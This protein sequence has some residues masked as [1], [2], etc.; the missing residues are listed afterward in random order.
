M[1]G[2]NFNIGIFT[3]LSRDHLDYHKSYKDYLSSKLLLFNNLLKKNSNVITDIDIP[4]YKNIKNII[5]K[6]QL[7]ISTIGL[8]NSTLEL[9]KHRYKENKQLFQIKYKN[10][11]YSLSVNLIGKVQIKKII[12]RPFCNLRRSLKYNLTFYLLIMI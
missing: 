9:I 12:I 11:I 4:E 2:L 8:N 1:D 6:K 10:K 5:K 7:K 3:N